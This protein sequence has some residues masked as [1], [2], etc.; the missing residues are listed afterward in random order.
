MTIDYGPRS[1]LINVGKP[2]SSDPM[3]AIDVELERIKTLNQLSAAYKRCLNSYGLK[4]YISL[5]EARGRW[6]EQT[7]YTPIAVHSADL[8]TID[9]LDN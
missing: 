7:R 4:G 8:L 6:A 3:R 2:A 5:E 1:I 9:E